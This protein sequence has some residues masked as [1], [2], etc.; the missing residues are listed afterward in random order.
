MLRVFTRFYQLY[1][2][3]FS[4][5]AADRVIY[6]AI[7]RH[8]VRSIMEIGMGTG[9]RA[10]R[11]IR[12][13]QWLRPAVPVRYVGIDQFEARTADDSPG[14]T[15][16]QAHR[17]LKSTAARVQLAPGDPLSALERVANSLRDI[18][19]V[20]ISHDQQG[21]SL[22]QAWFYLPRTLHPKAV[23]FQEVLDEKT[24]LSSFRR[25]DCSEIERRSRQFD[26]RRAA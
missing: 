1:L 25:I 10:V 16:K 2:A 5:P 26:R 19:L 11:M 12:M 14:I 6:R 9:C 20:V 8:R 23:V 13:A 15:L 7:R 4:K 17:Q 24:A 21:E 3:Y 22:E 18:Q